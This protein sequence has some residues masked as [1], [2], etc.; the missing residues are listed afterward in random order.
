ME[1][2]ELRP[3]LRPELRRDASR[4]LTAVN[5]TPNEVL[6]VALVALLVLGPK[7]LP[8]VMRRAG[9]MLSGMRRWTTDIRQEIDAAISPPVPE[10]PQTKPAAEPAPQTEPGPQ[11]EPASQTESA[12]E[13]SPQTEP[14]PAAD[15]EPHE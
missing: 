15:H 5:L 3:E 11:T 12:S 6:L 4:T 13:P 7:R 2:S 1:L 10:E 14:G 8:D 9:Q